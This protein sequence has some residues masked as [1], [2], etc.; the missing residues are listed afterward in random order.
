MRIIVNV[1]PL[2]ACCLLVMEGSTAVRATEPQSAL[3]TAGDQLINRFLQSDV[4]S[5]TSYRARRRLEAVTMGGKMSGLVEAWT[6][7]DGDGRLQFDV[8]REEGSGLVRHRVL[9][10]ALQTE[11]DNY[12]RGEVRKVELNRD[13]YDFRVGPSSGH[14]ATIDMQPKRISP[15]LLRG[16]VTVTRDG[17]VVQIDGSPSKRPS[18][19]TKRVDIVRRYS[20]I[21]GIRV[22]VEMASR[23]DVRIAGESAFRMT[24]E[25]TMIN[26]SPVATFASQ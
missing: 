24:Y 15:M 16:T 9:L 22:P 2:V 10:K 26:G 11:Q 18:W 12:N 19:W 14:F 6:Y 13:N 17:D 1:A 5:L 4:P 20:R 25:Y 8:I 23:A 21:N 3:V 7:I